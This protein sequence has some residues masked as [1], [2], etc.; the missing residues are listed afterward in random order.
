MKIGIGSLLV[1]NPETTLDA[2][3]GEVRQAESD[4][5]AFFSLPNIFGFDAISVLTLAGRETRR[6]ELAT[7]VTP[8]PPR[9]PFAIA[10][11]A[12]T[13][14]AACGGRFVLGIGLSHKVVIENMLGLS[15]AHPARQMREYL[16][17][18][19]PLVQGKPA[20]FSGELYRVQG[21]LQVKGGAPVPV[22]VAAL[23]PK[24]LALAGRLADGTATWMTGLRTLADHTVPT[25]RRAARDA[26]RGEPR[27]VAALPIAITGDPA[28]ARAAAS[29][30]FAIYGQL[31][32][33]RAMLD[34]EGAASPGDVALVGDEA[35]V[36]AG[37]ARL[38][39]AGVTHFAAS[40]FPADGGAVA[41]TRAF[42]RA[43][44]PS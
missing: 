25:I 20:A 42:L 37:L 36:R 18:L 10:Q 17:V 44:L 27:I 6:I 24:L 11:Q 7:G 14:Q 41:R 32:S 23:G 12:L 43:E 39:E 40:L 21:A 38:R 30:V 34:R 9:H 1:G 15:Y 2:L 31:P 28:G 5:F 8:T 13:A 4:G 29:Q 22:V 19:M 33:Y 35:A 26:G 3:V 16:E